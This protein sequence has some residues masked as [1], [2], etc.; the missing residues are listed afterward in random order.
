[1]P[2]NPAHIRLRRARAQALAGGVRE[3]SA[4]AVVRRAVAIQA[5]DAVAADLGI[6][7]RGA[8]LTAGG[9][10][11]A[12]ED[13]RSIVRSW[14]MRG[15]L[16]TV[17]AEDVRWLLR[18]LGP[19]LVAATAAR[20][21]QLGL[22]DALRSRA[23]ELFRAA[24]AADGPLTRAELTERL[25]ALGVGPVGQGPIHL[26]RH[27]AL[28]GVLCHGP[29]RAGEA[30]YV[31]L[32]DWLADHGTDPVRDDEA[33]AAELA[34]R[35]AAGYGPADADDFAVWSGLP[36]PLSRKAWA[37]AGA[38]ASS[39]GGAEAS[40]ADTGGAPDMR[41]I[42]AF[43]NYLV[44]YRTRELAVPA[45]YE[46]QVWPGGGIIRATVLADGLAVG[47]W[48]RQAPGLPPRIDAF[49]GPDGPD[50]PQGPDGRDGPDALE[51]LGSAAR[52]A[53]DAEAAAV[54]AFLAPD[55]P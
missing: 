16:H 54:A 51:R 15:T 1:M 20:Y 52:A 32:D 39:R 33:A 41:L 11:A 38:S 3:R 5:Q 27:A 14:F 7:V 18:L 42:P 31:L 40:E 21:R 36:K 49:G 46:K 29:M 19:R 22:D 34:R 53:L 17:P 10:R 13:D 2:T 37:P 9:V 8:G 25:G 23:D 43:D 30:T 6:R 50:G 12:Y 47:T 55:A 28:T 26:I 4:A 44:A 48:S 45:A 24:L 35:Y